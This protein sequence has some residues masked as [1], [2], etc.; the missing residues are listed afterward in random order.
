MVRVCKSAESLAHTAA[1]VF[2]NQF[3]TAVRKHQQFSV[4]LSG[5]HT[6]E[7]TYELLIEDP[8]CSQVDWSKVHIFWGD[9]RCVPVSDPRS[10][11]AMAS[12][13]FVAKVKP[14]GAKIYP[15]LCTQDPVRAAEDYEI[16]LRNYLGDHERSF[17]LIFLGLGRDGHTA[18]LFPESPAL[19]ETLRWVTTVKNTSEPFF[20]ITLTI[21][22][23]NRTQLAL[24]L[25]TGKE[26]ATLLHEVMENREGA[27]LL[28][29]QRIRPPDG[30]LLWLVSE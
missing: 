15:I 18:S 11:Y 2:V 30:E 7:R 8:L 13:T 24:F 9:E 28:P 16:T 4:V 6:P 17:D 25:V 12:K 14:L 1:E 27:I 19:N 29:A 21:P 20:R 26:K 5:G 22:I 10:N 23:L 3:Q